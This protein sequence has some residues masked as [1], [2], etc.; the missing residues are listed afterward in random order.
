MLFVSTG[1]S[2][3]R[4]V[5]C[6]M[7]SLLMIIIR[8]AGP[9]HHMDGSNELFSLI[10]FWPKSSLLTFYRMWRHQIIATCPCKHHFIARSC[11]KC[12]GDDVSPNYWKQSHPSDTCTLVITE[13][14][15]RPY[16]DDLLDFF[17]PPAVVLVS[18][19]WDSRSVICQCAL[20][21]SHCNHSHSELYQWVEIRFG[22]LIGPLFRVSGISYIPGIFYGSRSCVVRESE[23]TPMNG[24]KSY[25]GNFVPPCCVLK[26]WHNGSLRCKFAFLFCSDY[27]VL[28]SDLWKAST[29]CGRYML[30]I[31]YIYAA[32]CTCSTDCI[33]N[34]ERTSCPGVQSSVSALQLIDLSSLWVLILISYFT[35]EF[36]RSRSAKFLDVST[37]RSRTI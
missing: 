5:V 36:G 7:Y 11:H 23:R 19:R 28:L 31:I 34:I 10:F 3:S 16:S 4:K 27:F 9:V 17:F 30:V 29:D 20:S 33:L 35:P 6:I 21:E 15:H 8:Q 37:T 22:P 26:Y 14:P 24:L 13:E 2:S 1:T 32:E 18:W 25:V 12:V